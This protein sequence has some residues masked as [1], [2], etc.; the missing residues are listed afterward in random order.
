MR[1]YHQPLDILA[2]WGDIPLRLRVE[3]CSAAV[4]GSF[5]PSS[6]DYGFLEGEALARSALPSR[7][8]FCACTQHVLF[9]SLE[10]KGLALGFP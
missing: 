10:G 4:T 7:T 8:A 3:F 1:S 5:G 2:I 6:L 9:C